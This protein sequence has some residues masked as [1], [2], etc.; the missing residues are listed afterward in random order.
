MD[1]GVQVPPRA[2]IM[3]PTVA[4]WGFCFTTL[5]R[6]PARAHTCYTDADIILDNPHHYRETSGNLHH[7]MAGHNSVVYEL[8]DTPITHI[9]YNRSVAEGSN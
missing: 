7:R 4:G 6:A 2:H 1:V 5:P 8:V 9:H 3:T